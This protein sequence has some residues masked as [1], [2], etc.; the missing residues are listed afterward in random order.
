MQ[1]GGRGGRGGPDSPDTETG[2]ECGDGQD[3]DGDGTS[4]C[5]DPDCATAP[6]CMQGGR[7]GRGGPGGGCNPATMA[8]SAT[9]VTTTCC[10][11]A[12]CSTGVPS[13]CTAACA[14]VFLDFMDDCGT[15]V[16]QIPGMSQQYAA[17]QEQCHG[18]EQGEDGAGRPPPP[19]GVVDCGM[20]SAVQ[21]TMQCSNVRGDFCSSPCYA[22]LAPF[23]AQCQD[24]MT[25]T[26]TMM[27]SSAMGMAGSCGGAP[28][29]GGGGRGGGGGASDISAE[30]TTLFNDEGRATLIAT[31]LPSGDITTMP[32]KCSHACADVLVPLYNSCGTVLQAAVP[33]IDSFFSLCET[34]QGGGH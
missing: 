4:D 8:T 2:R 25:P 7:G 34:T 13:T 28:A 10:T 18:V 27:L 20:N 26:L 17:L 21:I 15:M 22:T 6:P 5:D 32:T 30:C 11:G 12:D 14:P 24:Q 16:Q 29:T 9:L 33:G 19:P 23:L 3:N 31:C 1:Q